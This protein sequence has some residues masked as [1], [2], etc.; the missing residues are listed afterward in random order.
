MQLERGED[1]DESFVGYMVPA[2]VKKGQRRATSK[3]KGDGNG[4]RVIKVQGIE[5]QFA[6]D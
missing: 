6:F 1:I 4:V 2:D 3:E 5:V